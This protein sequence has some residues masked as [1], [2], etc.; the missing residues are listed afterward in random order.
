MGA[1]RV[2]RGDHHGD[3]GASPTR[4]LLEGGSSRLDR[5]M[6]GK[7]MGA[8]AAQGVAKKAADTTGFNCVICQCFAFCTTSARKRRMRGTN[9]PMAGRGSVQNGGS[10]RE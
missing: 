5:L 7:E 10:R 8:L 4:R 6:V 3:D 2:G 1:A 9:D